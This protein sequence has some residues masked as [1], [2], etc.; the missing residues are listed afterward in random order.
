[1]LTFL[2]ITYFAG[3]CPKSIPVL[4]G[5]LLTSAAGI[6]GSYEEHRNLVT[7]NI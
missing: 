4:L 1:M 6:I 3:T 5:D 7:A 2:A